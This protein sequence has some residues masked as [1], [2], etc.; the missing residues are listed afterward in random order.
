MHRLREC[1]VAGRIPY[2]KSHPFFSAGVERNSEMAMA[3]GRLV[4]GGD[5]FAADIFAVA[6]DGFD[7]FQRKCPFDVG[8]NF[9]PCALALDG[10]VVDENLA[11]G[12]E[13]LAGAERAVDGTPVFEAWYAVELDVVDVEIAVQIVVGEFLIGIDLADH[14]FGPAPVVHVV[15]RAE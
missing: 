3:E 8:N 4:G 9:A 14:I 7:E 13:K 10:P 12:Y 5:E 2:G 15:E 1:A 11:C 6:P